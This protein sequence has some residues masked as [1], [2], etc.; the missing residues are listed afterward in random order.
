[1]KRRHFL[2][3][4]AALAAPSNVK[5]QSNRVLRYV[6]SAGVVLLDPLATTIF[7]TFI[8]GLQIFES[9]YS[10]DENLQPR[11]QMAAGH[12]IEDDGKRWVITLRDGLRFHDGEPVL[13][14]D[15]VASINRWMKRDA[16]GQTLA[17]RL[18]ALEASDDRT[19]VFRLKKPFPQ[20]PYVLGKTMP[21][22]SAIMPAHLAA[23]D[24]TQPITEL[25]GSG[26]YRFVANEFS[27]NSL[28]VLARFEAYRPRDEPPSGT[29][30]ARIAKLDRIEWQVIPEAST[31]VNALLTGEID[32]I[33]G[34]PPDLL[35]TVQGHPQVVV[36]VIDRLGSY[37][38]VRPNHVSGPTANVAIRRAI[39]AALDGREII[40]AAIGDA[41]GMVTAPIGVFAPGSPSANSAG[42]EHL[43]PKPL[44][45][46]RTMLKL[47]GYANE[48]LVLL[49]Q[50]DVATQDVML[51]VIARRLVEA[52]FNVDDQVM[53]LA[54]V[55]KRRNSREAPDKGGW[56][57]QIGIGSCV[58]SFSP[59]L[60][61]G[62]RTG[63]AAWIGWPDDPV[64]E[65]LRERWLD[66]ADAA[67]Q[68]QLAGKIQETAL[69]EVLFIP[70][71]RYQISSAWRSN[72]S[73]ILKMNMP[74]MWNVSKS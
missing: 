7:P 9:L 31:Q 60:N 71:G 64:M 40:T 14:R 51:Q 69:S 70:L 6:S 52:G 8:L 56:S 5:A 35:P 20:L 2:A 57:L 74:I 49:H 45:E 32:W 54:T 34:V 25:V 21:Y 3:G 4:M 59:M 62:L 1:M 24:L 18:D 63:A 38:S 50:R 65:D 16:A 73:G 15:C 53:D 44:A 10:V 55:V 11:P 41:A 67:E 22:P 66:S 13:A 23:A 26:P 17:L 72:V 19:V 58:D 37:P 42:M 47:A 28:V 27:A 29:A 46:V 61:I 33:Y 36:D 30:G 39:M 43:G 48:R 68:K 12:T